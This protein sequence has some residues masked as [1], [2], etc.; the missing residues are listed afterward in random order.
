MSTNSNICFQQT[1]KITDICNNKYIFDNNY[2][3]ICYGLYETSGNNYVISNIPK[4]YPIGFYSN[5][6]TNDLSN[7]LNYD[8]SYD[9]NDPIIIYVSTGSDVSFSNGDYFRFYDES[10]NLINI[11][12]HNVETTLTTN[13]DN[14]YFMRNMTYKF[15]TINDFSSV[16]P[17]SISGSILSS[18][19][20]LFLPGISFEIIIP[21]NADN[22]DNIVFY[23]DI[24]HINSRGNFKILVDSSNINYYYG[25]ISFTVDNSFNDS[26][27]ISIKSYPFNSVSEINNE[28]L[29]NYSNTCL[30][31]F[32]DITAIAIDLANNNQECLNLVSKAKILDTNLD[33]S[34]SDLSYT[35][36][37][38]DENHHSSELDNNFKINLNYGLFDASY[39][40]INIDQQYPIT[41]LNSDISNLIYVDESYDRTNIIY[42]SNAIIQNLDNSYNSY[43][44]YYGDIKLIVNGDFLSAEIYSFDL[45]NQKTFYKS[46]KFFYTNL[47]T[48]PDN[49]N[50]INL[51]D[52][53]LFELVNQEGN[54][55][56]IKYH[57]PNNIYKLTFN[58]EYIE[59][60]FVVEDRYGHDI[61][62]L[63]IDNA[64]KIK[65]D[66]CF[67]LSEFYIY[68]QVE[69]YEGIS[70][71]LYRKVSIERGPFIEISSNYFKNNNSYTNTIELNT[72]TYNSNYNFY[73]DISVYFYDNNDK[74]V[75]LP[76]TVELD[77]QFYPD[78]RTYVNLTTESKSE[79]IITYNELIFDDLKYYLSKNIHLDSLERLIFS[80]ITNL[81]YN[82]PDSYIILDNNSALP[83]NNLIR[84]TG[85]K[86]ISTFQ[87]GDV[88]ELDGH[89]NIIINNIDNSNSIISISQSYET[90]NLSTN[91]FVNNEKFII[92][93]ED[94]NN[95][96]NNIEIS[97]NF[98]EINFFDKTNFSFID[99]SFIGTHELTFNTE[100]LNQGDY[101]YYNFS[102]ITDISNA[103]RSIYINVIDNIKPTLKFLNE[104]STNQSLNYTYKYPI[105]ISFDIIN[106]VNINHVNSI[107]NVNSNKP[108]IEFD[109]NSIYNGSLSY[110]IISPQLDNP[111]DNIIYETFSTSYII[112]YQVYDL[113]GNLSD[114]SVNLTLEIKDVP[115][116]E[117][118]G[119]ATKTIS[120][121][122]G[123]IDDGIII[124][125]NG[126]DTFFYSSDIYT[127]NGFNSDTITNTVNGE[128]VSFTIMGTFSGNTNVINNYELSY[129]VTVSG[130]ALST[131]NF[132]N[133]TILVRDSSGPTIDFCNNYVAP[134]FTHSPDYK[135]FSLNIHTSFDDLSSILHDISYSDNYFADAS[136]SVFISISGSSDY[137]SSSDV[138]LNNYPDGSLNTLTTY[139]FN[140]SI[141]D[142]CDNSLNI[143]RTVEIVDIDTPT[144]TF[145][146]ID[147]SYN[148]LPL[149]E[150]GLDNI[151]FSFS[152]GNTSVNSNIIQE[153]SSII[154]GFTLNDNFDSSTNITYS[155]EP[156]ITSIE[157]SLNVVDTSFIITYNLSDNQ[158]NNAT[159]Q[160]IVNIINNIPPEISYNSLFI[161]IINISFGDTL[162]N[163]FNNISAVH[164]R[165]EIVT[166]ISIDISYIIPDLINSISGNTIYDP[167]ALIYNLGNFDISYFTIDS[168]QDL[169]SEIYTKQINIVNNGPIFDQDFTT[170]THEAGETISDASLILGIQAFSVYDQFYYFHN[171]PD[172]SY[173]GTNFSITLE[174][175][176]NQ[177]NPIFGQYKITYIAADISGISSEI[178]RTIDISDTKGPV[179]YTICGDLFYNNND[180]NEDNVLTYLI[181][182][183]TDYIEYGAV[184][185]DKGDDNYLFDI[186]ITKQYF[187]I[188]GETKTEI[189]LN[190][191]IT[192]TIDTSYEIIYTVTDSHNNDSSINRLIHIIDSN[193]K[194][195]LFPKIEISGTIINIDNNF[196]NNLSN[197]SAIN[198]FSLDNLNYN[199]FNK[200][201]TYEA[202]KQSKFDNNIEFKLDASTN[203]G[204][205]IADASKNITY[206][207]NS[208]KVDIYE[209]IFHAIDGDEFKTELYKFNVI[210]TTPPILT[211]KSNANFTNINNLNIPFLSESN[212][213]KLILDINYLND[214]NKN[215]Q[216]Y[217]IKDTCD[218]T[219][220]F[221]DPGININDIVNG[222]TNF[223][224]EIIPS[225]SQFSYS[226][227]YID[228]SSGL[229]VSNNYLIDHSGNYTQIYSIYDSNNNE[230]T[231]SRNIN[232]DYFPPFID[233][234]NS[235]DNNNNSY[236]KLYHNVYSKYIDLGGT[237]KDYYFGE[238]SYNNLQI[239]ENFN[240][241]NLGS[242]KITY[243][244]Q[245]I[246]GKK[247]NP[248]RNID[249]VHINCLLTDSYLSIDSDTSY[250]TFNNDSYNGYHKYGLYDGSYNIYV[251]ISDAI[252][253]I[254][255]DLN[256]NLD[257]SNLI[258]ISGD[259]YSSAISPYDFNICNYYWGNVTINVINNFN[260]V[261]IE[262][263]NSNIITEDIFLYSD[264]CEFVTFNK[265]YDFSNISI[266]D[267]SFIIDVDYDNS[268]N[269]QKYNN[270]YFT[271]NGE[272]RKNLYLS[273]GRYR[274]YQTGHK[275]FYNQIKFSIIQDGTHNLLDGIEYT[276]NINNNKLAGTANAYTE[277]LI[278]TTTPLTL[279]YYSKNFPNMG[280]KIEIKN[281]IV[282]TKNAISLNNNI[283]NI[284][285]SNI[286]LNY[287][288]IYTYTI[289]DIYNNP[290]LPYDI[291]YKPLNL[292]Y[293][294]TGY[295][296]NTATLTITNEYPPNTSNNVNIKKTAA[297]GDPLHNAG[298]SSNTIYYNT[299]FIQFQLGTN[300]KDFFIGVSPPP[301]S[302]PS[303]T[304]WAIKD[305]VDP[306]FTAMSYGATF[307]R[308]ADSNNEGFN[309]IGIGYNGTHDNLGN[310][311]LSVSVNDIIIIWYDG[312]TLGYYLVKS[313]GAIITITEKTE[314][315]IP[316]SIGVQFDTVFGGLN[317]EIKNLYI[318]SM[319]PYASNQSNFKNGI[320]NNILNDL[321]IDNSE[322]LN[323]IR[324]KAHDKASDVLK[325]RIFLNQHFYEISGNI[326]NNDNI[327]SKKKYIGITHQNL[328][329]NVNI[330]KNTNKIIFKK[331]KTNSEDPN[332]IKQDI[333]DNY[334]FNTRVNYS[335]SNI[336]YY[337]YNI[338][339]SI[340]LLENKNSFKYELNIKNLFFTNNE[341]NNYNYYF[342][343]NYLLNNKF[344]IDNFI[345]K[346][347]E[348]KYDK[349]TQVLNGNNAYDY[350][351]NEY[352]L[353]SRLIFN[354][355]TDNVIIFNL[356]IYLDLS[357]LNIT[358]LHIEFIKNILKTTETNYVFDNNNLFFQEYVVTIYSD[359]SDV[360]IEELLTQN[361]NVVF[362]RGNI[363]FKNNLI[364]SLDASNI[365]YK[366]YNNLYI[367]NSIN[368]I[369]NILK[370]KVFLSIKDTSLNITET[371]GLTQEN[372]WHNLF[373]DTNSDKLIFHNYDLSTVNYQ[374]NDNNLTLEKTINESVN[375]KKFLVDISSN[376]IYKCFKDEK[377]L[378]TENYQKLSES[379]YNIFITYTISNEIIDLSNYLLNKFDIRPIYKNDRPI[380]RNNNIYNDNSIT[381]YP[382]NKL[383]S[384]SYLLDLN[385][386]FDIRL[387]NKIIPYNNI[388]IDKLYYKLTDISYTNEFNIFDIISEKNIIYD[389]D[390]IDILNNLEST[391][392]IVNFKVNYLTNLLFVLY[393]N[394]NNHNTNEYNL[395]NNINLQNLTQ[396]FNNI[397]YISNNYLSSLTI[398]SITELY[399]NLFNNSKNLLQNYN[400]L[401]ENYNLRHEYFVP[402]NDLYYTYDKTL[403]ILNTHLLVTDISLLNF[404]VG[405]VIQNL[406][407]IK[408]ENEFIEVINNNDQLF[409]LQNFNEFQILSQ[410]FLDFI[411]LK[412]SVDTLKY[413]M[414]LRHNIFYNLSSYNYD[415]LYIE[416]NIT[417]F[418]NKLIN[419]YDTLNNDIINDMSNIYVQ[420]YPIN[421]ENIDNSFNINNINNITDLSNNINFLYNNYNLVYNLINNN[422]NLDSKQII[423]HPKN[424]VLTDSKILINS[425]KSNSIQLKLDI[426]YNSYLYPNLYLDSVILDVTIPDIT[427]PT[428]EFNNLLVP[429]S[430]NLNSNSIEQIIEI[431]INDI[432]YIDI[433]QTYTD[434]CSNDIEYRYLQIDSAE[435]SQM[436]ESSNNF[437]S[438]I[439]VDITNIFIISD[440]D[441]DGIAIIDISYI[442]KDNANNINTV[443]RPIK[444]EQAFLSPKFY[445]NLN[446]QSIFVD[447]TNV[448]A[449]NL[450]IGSNLTDTIIRQNIIALD[451]ADNLNNITNNITY[452]IRSDLININNGQEYTEITNENIH[453]LNNLSTS[454]IV[455][456]NDAIKY[457]VI[458]TKEGINA[459]NFTLL[460]R[461]IEIVQDDELIKIIHC[462]YPKV[463]YKSIQ[464]NYKLG[465]SACNA[466]RLSKIIINNRNF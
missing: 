135:D 21:Y 234:S 241:N 30:Y 26:S 300:N 7:I 378:N 172:I 80:N 361:Q 50:N 439:T 257:I 388:N 111:I 239:A 408:E 197:S 383:H 103:S 381:Y 445:Y 65:T 314:Y 367:D 152:A 274:F 94:L 136:L 316:E 426:Y 105:G 144:I 55:F 216:N 174:N 454:I 165:L 270:Q 34:I 431:L 8:I 177:I 362:S 255:Y 238:I 323:A 284:D 44:Y 170:I 423:F 319:C 57:D 186:S 168:N 348:L 121:N 436:I 273:L 410:L 252:R 342:V 332:N 230:T 47:C 441:S 158:G 71:E 120:V 37:F 221:S 53:L 97:G 384:H 269:P 35:Y 127:T 46:Q 437:Y 224:N 420:L 74:I 159:Q 299:F 340:N 149:V 28:N 266:F 440:F 258:T 227:K 322:L 176:F 145:L 245:N 162:F 189:N 157:S 39:I 122:S 310:L 115:L 285:Q 425:Y 312:A 327:I 249:V 309:S 433:D 116:L 4:N 401:V 131:A 427:P 125:Y 68:Y 278:D 27:F 72:N 208:K 76:F 336:L 407:F 462:C 355:I 415:N 368:E 73:N 283:I 114:N 413:E 352:L 250:V 392:H 99:L 235:I 233:F 226:V 346:I 405:N 49:V 211:F 199:H 393:D 305:F 153:I 54:N 246:L 33:T 240:E 156:D 104:D 376:D 424:Y 399:F 69:D 88:L 112:Q 210:D 330:N 214:L 438:L 296:T 292:N 317:G 200:T 326:V 290:L 307:I 163:P 339:T 271:I 356:Q 247:S 15:I 232:V 61:S 190:E 357:K 195:I 215:P 45:S 390:V 98:I 119:N 398:Q 416:Y 313:N 391:I 202:T 13:N 231:I 328:N 364:Y 365:L 334:L 16:H 459:T 184:A 297:S 447:S 43:N 38:N 291:Y 32:S 448:P 406:L 379:G 222:N 52:D 123:Y 182:R 329:H 223:I 5:Q 375:S 371:N 134:G 306:W 225:N 194:P 83:V 70:K 198:I 90:L 188:I 354:S 402:I 308:I 108:F 360:L 359:I 295:S 181:E 96:S 385:D 41:I 63:L 303:S 193:T 146:Q 267:S 12:N 31:I 229:E 155:I 36:L 254:N 349:I 201:F 81:T 148:T 196:N 58:R 366:L 20:E 110:S 48:D 183:N 373:L 109:D 205:D 160:R 244:I 187:N 287:S 453:V 242:Q 421:F 243:E 51:S 133:R 374:V 23:Q 11:R 282:F 25:D 213:D 386:F 228:L 335:T 180:N 351:L 460:E 3:D 260:R 106:D 100:G 321:N 167:S 66:I 315:T 9:Q 259:N 463:Y 404:T 347:N 256:K 432:S 387:Y 59:H 166:D 272:K 132:I 251:D 275:N 179:F 40:I 418:F 219:I 191:I 280:G 79:D 2:Q 377:I 268:S 435:N 85:G 289:N 60:G 203:D 363:E 400:K 209:I 320:L 293:P 343:K 142:P 169:S 147:L 261:S 417:N 143:V 397:T 338:D 141:T 150:F 286:L 140:Y 281:S 84:L 10:Y 434:I 414:K 451:T 137:F 458:S 341:I 389:R 118:S 442:V 331:Y 253:L 217:F 311:N 412:N 276:K 17:F 164:P 262:S 92:N 277:L 395:I 22:S 117:L 353:S 129:Y 452:S 207:I 396:T 192:T 95:S 161:D 151:D 422:Y 19:Y 204:A 77:G 264:K 218:N 419:N 337:D 324:A 444:V 220:K 212:K 101:L 345:Y 298:V 428:I 1:N 64:P 288:L 126:I 372:I 173:T 236:S 461:N 67:N 455:T 403:N 382:N 370:N 449:L 78:D 302:H 325:N 93:I 56:T 333:C 466:M 91:I 107:V 429:L 138:S 62:Y 294:L 14:F 75:N 409:S 430:Q 18:P 446:N 394:I 154:Y 171:S 318:N 24:S 237:V 457:K 29:F 6:I 178:I 369:D 464:H 86:N 350:Y 443:S 279:Y 263:L 358:D 248:Y 42:N 130:Q 380:Y 304:T 128:T 102:S 465:A 206:S 185:F 175:S 124:R 265:Y 450:K 301:D 89:P 456:Y 87:L 139:Y 82:N 411:I 113:C 344:V